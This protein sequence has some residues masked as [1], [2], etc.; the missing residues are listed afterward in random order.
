GLPSPTSHPTLGTGGG[1]P[2]LT[3]HAATS[4]TAADDGRRR[5]SSPLPLHAS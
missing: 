2:F 3:S 5:R 1:L 4:R